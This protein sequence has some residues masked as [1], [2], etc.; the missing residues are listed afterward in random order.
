MA[1][2]AVGGAHSGRKTLNPDIALVPFLDLL[3]CCVMFLLVTAVWNQLG[4]VS[5]RQTVPGPSSEPAPPRIVRYLAIHATGYELGS[6]AGERQWIAREDSA[7]LQR[8]LSAQ[9]ELAGADEGRLLLS[10]EDG[11]PYQDLVTAMDLAVGAGFDV[12][13]VGER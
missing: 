10:A 6:N 12:L 13:D 4:S 2:I 8:A 9:R 3:L 11:V 1:S 7:E 5:V